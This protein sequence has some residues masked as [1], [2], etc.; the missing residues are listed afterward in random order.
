MAKLQETEILLPMS[1]GQVRAL[2]EEMKR[3][4]QSRVTPELAAELC[5]RAEEKATLT[6]TCGAGLPSSLCAQFQ[7]D[8]AAEA[9]RLQNDVNRFK[10]Y[11]VANIG[12][13]IGF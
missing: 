1:D 12:V 3:D 13:T 2:L 7:S 9:V 11:P 4:P 6:G 5:R 8:V 10:Y